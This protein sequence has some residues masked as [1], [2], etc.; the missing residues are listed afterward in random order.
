MEIKSTSITNP[1]F[2]VFGCICVAL[3]VQSNF[4][5]LN[6]LIPPTEHDVPFSGSPSLPRNSQGSPWNVI[7]GLS[8]QI[9][10]S[11]SPVNVTLWK[12][13][14]LVSLQDVRAARRR[15]KGNPS[16][17]LESLA[18]WNPGWTQPRSPEDNFFMHNY[19][20][21]RHGVVQTLTSL[22]WIARG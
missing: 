11:R 6:L 8:D 14:P 10:V 19:T 17:F 20:Q 13:A 9:Q 18:Q 3:F 15:G 4:L 12:N 5:T 16:Q 7:I 22:A 21:F 2:G 1:Y